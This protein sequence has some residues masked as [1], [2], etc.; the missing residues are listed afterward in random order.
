[1]DMYIT[2]RTRLWRISLL[3][4]YFRAFMGLLF[5][6]ILIGNYRYGTLRERVTVSFGIARRGS[7]CRASTPKCG[8]QGIGRD[9]HIAEEHT[10]GSIATAWVDSLGGDRGQL[11]RFLIFR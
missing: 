11:T 6:Q 5:H 3:T 7:Y 8:N 2:P 9:T 10:R 4:A 1:M